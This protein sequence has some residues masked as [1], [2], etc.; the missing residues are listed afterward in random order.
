MFARFFCLPNQGRGKDRIVLCATS[1]SLLGNPS[2]VVKPVC[3]VTPCY[4][5][6]TVSQISIERKHATEPTESSTD[7]RAFSS[8]STRS[9]SRMS[10]VKERLSLEAPLEWPFVVGPEGTVGVCK[11][12]MCKPICT[13]MSTAREN[14]SEQMATGC[15]FVTLNHGSGRSYADA[16][17]VRVAEAHFLSPSHQMM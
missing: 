9:F 4:L 10:S 1:M 3:I 13:A 17:K 2:K 14:G 12:S 8:D 6:C 15:I 11:S 7:P 5:R 16:G